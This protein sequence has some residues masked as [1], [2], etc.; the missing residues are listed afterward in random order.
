V[1]FRKHVYNEKYPG[2]VKNLHCDRCGRKIKHGETYYSK[3]TL[4]PYKNQIEGHYCE[5]CY[6][7]FFIDVEEEVILK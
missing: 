7:H 2:R 4:T 3:Y 6:E 1:P 5:D